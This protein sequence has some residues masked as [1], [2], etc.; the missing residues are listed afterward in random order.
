[1]SPSSKSSIHSN[2]YF[3]DLTEFKEMKLTNTLSAM[4][5]KDEVYIHL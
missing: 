4:I 3:E 5:G 2:E 1:M